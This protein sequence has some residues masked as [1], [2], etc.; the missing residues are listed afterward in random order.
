MNQLQENKS[1]SSSSSS[2]GSSSSS[3]SSRQQAMHQCGEM[4]S[5]EAPIRELLH[6]L[7]QLPLS[8]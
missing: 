2:S 5:D 1:S 6:W 7:Q 3:S 4:S 8:Q